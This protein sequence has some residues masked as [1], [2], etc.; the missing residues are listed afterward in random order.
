MISYEIENKTLPTVCINLTNV[1]FKIQT[2]LHFMAIEQLV[3]LNKKI[4]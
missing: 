2:D 3:I 4:D 1:G